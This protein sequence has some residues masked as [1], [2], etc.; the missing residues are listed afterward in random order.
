MIKNLIKSPKEPVPTL[1]ELAGRMVV[2]CNIQHN[3]GDLPRR[4]E[5]NKFTSLVV[6][7]AS[8]IL[9][10]VLHNAEWCTSCGGPIFFHYKSEITFGCF[11]IFR[12]PLY[13]ITCSPQCHV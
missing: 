1:V 13:S 10:V 11:G 2:K 4:L 9:V 8:I 5:G 3:P 6:M 7:K 12:V